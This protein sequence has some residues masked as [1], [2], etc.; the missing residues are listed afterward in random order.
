MLKRVRLIAQIAFFALFVVTFFALMRLPAAYDAP[1][2]WYLRLNPLTTLLTTIASRSIYL[3]LA[4]LGLVIA[5]LTVVFGRF[6]CGMMCPLGAIVDFSDRYLFRHM[7]IRK[8]CP[9][10]YVQKLKYVLLAALLAMAIFGGMAPLIMG[11]ILLVTRVFTLV[12]NPVIAVV[13]SQGRAVLAPA[14]A[15]VG[16]DRLLYE[17]VKVPL[18]YGVLGA[19]LIFAL[20]V[21][22]GLFDRR[23][24]CQHVCPTGGFFGLLSRFA[25]F[26]RK[27]HESQCS[28]CRACSAVCPVHAISDSG[29]S[30]SVAEC[31][32]CGNCTAAKKNCNSFGFASISKTETRGADLQRRHAVAGV[33]GGV[34]MLPALRA[35]ASARRDSSG[36][37]IRP[38]GAV[39]EEQFLG[40][41]I[42]CG[43]CMKV[44][45]TNAIQPCTMGDGFQRVYTPKIVPR[46]GG[47]EEKCHICGYTCP[48]GAIRNLTYEEK[49]FAKIGTAVINRH[50]CLAWEQNKECLVCDEICPY[51]A[52]T[53][54]IV[55]TTTGPFK[56]PV[57]NED[58]CLGCGMCEQHCPIT[59]RAAI[60]VFRFGENRRASGPYVRDD[61]KA[62]I[63]EERRRS[64][65][66][67]GRSL[68]S[69]WQRD[70]E[71][72]GTSSASASHAE[73]ETTQSSL[74]P[75]FIQ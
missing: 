69:E 50:R 54:M 12:L 37:V 63:L 31:I 19:F 24:W 30:T 56:V 15:G 38:P 39:P 53:P 75:G 17:T 35:N 40:R 7:R 10:R 64:D 66:D 20:A 5:A 29:K 18:Y 21:L 73:P 44:C 51:N 60:V 26:R 59:D 62:Q 47:C 34:F 16:Y 48:T 72:N 14:L 27:V 22:G 70:V 25:L 2:M 46:I 67:I 32:V 6:F 4:V 42:S 36:R 58:L 13:S 52:I 9:P 55:E 61:E 45:P 43:A 71:T 68:T 33:L 23:F 28:S 1:G 65:E 11:P 41:C 49:R 57:V 8:A 3:P 74:P